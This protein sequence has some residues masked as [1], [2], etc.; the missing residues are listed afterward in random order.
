MPAPLVPTSPV[1]TPV[2]S[3]IAAAVF[4]LFHTP[5]WVV[6]DSVIVDPAQTVAG[7]GVTIAPTVGK[8]F[9]TIVLVTLPE[10]PLPSLIE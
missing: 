7:F 10:H 9:I 6:S 2:E 4:P 5:P 1:T 8:L 3:M